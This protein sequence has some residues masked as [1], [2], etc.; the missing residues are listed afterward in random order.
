MERKIFTT[1]E[2]RIRFDFEPESY[3]WWLR[4]A[5][6]SISRIFLIIAHNDGKLYG[7]G[8]NATHGVSPA[9]RIA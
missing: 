9:F 2:S 4:S 6:S 1:N 8:A 3:Y 7:T 5:Y